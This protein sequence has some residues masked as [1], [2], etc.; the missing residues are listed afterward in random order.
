M[1]VTP[2]LPNH[3]FHEPH[4]TRVAFSCNSWFGASWEVA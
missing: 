3:E 1:S 4:E 2:R